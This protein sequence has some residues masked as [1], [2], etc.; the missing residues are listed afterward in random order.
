M[1][2]RLRPY[3]ESDAKMLLEI[4]KRK[5]EQLGRQFWLPKLNDERSKVF[6]LDRNEERF[7]GL[8]LRRIHELGFV[9]DSPEAVRAMLSFQPKIREICRRAGID[10]VVAFIP[11]VLVDSDERKRGMELLAERGGFDRLVDFAA[12]ETHIEGA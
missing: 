11:R 6:V 10:E 4:T 9:G 12:Y 8:Y 3:E 5:S 7:A 2:Y 1:R